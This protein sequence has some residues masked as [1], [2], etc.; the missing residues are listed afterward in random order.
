MTDERMTGKESL[1]KVACI[2]FEPLF[3]QVERN[4]KKTLELINEAADNGATLIVLPELANTGY[5]FNTRAECYSLAEEV[6]N[7][8]TTQ[9]WMKVAKEREL[10]IVAGITER[11]GINTYNSAVIVGPD[12]WI[13]THRKVTLWNE[14]KMFFEPGN[15]GNQVFNTKIGRISAMI[16]YDMWFPEQWR[17][18][19]LGGADIVCCPT[20]WVTFEGLPNDIKNFGVYLAEAAA[21]SNNIFVAA[22]DRVGTERGCPFPGRSLIVDRNGCP[23]VGPIGEDEETIYA[24]INLMD[25]RRLNYNEFNK[26][27]RDRRDDLWGNYLGKDEN[28]KPIPGR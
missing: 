18:C 6:P 17:N 9:E 10:Y 23:I 14:E 15:L 4:V 11:E 1:V 27:L 22:A 2:Q 13:G 24:E 19:A 16:C 3:G 8:P 7:G 26:V 28:N 21:H 20:N 25:A 5:V 12:G